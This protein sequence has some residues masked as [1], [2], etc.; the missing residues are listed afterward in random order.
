[1]IKALLTAL[2]FF[3]LFIMGQDT[4]PTGEPVYIS[5]TL[6]AQSGEVYLDSVKIDLPKTFIDPE[7]IKEVKV[8]KGE[9]AKVYS[10]NKGA[11]LI[12]RNVQGDIIALQEFAASLKKGSGKLKKVATLKLVVND[13]PIEDASGYRIELSAVRRVSILNYQQKTFAHEGSATVLIT[14]KGFKD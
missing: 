14:L 3:P 10:S 7:N 9:S 2:L 12:T 8:F 5:K 4:I 6:T 13:Q 11:T 1:M